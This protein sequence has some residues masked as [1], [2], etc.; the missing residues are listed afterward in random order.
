MRVQVTPGSRSTRRRAVGAIRGSVLAVAILAL[1]A[2][3]QTATETVT[4]TVTKTA[5]TTTTA[6]AAAATRGSATTT[7][8][9]VG[10]RAR[11]R[12]TTRVAWAACDANVDVVAPATSCGFAQNAFYEYWNSGYSATIRVY[13]PALGATLATRCT[14]SATRATCRTGD[15]GRARFALSA[16]EAYSSDQAESYAST[17]DIGPESPSASSWSSDSADDAAT[18]GDDGV[19]PPVGERI[20]NF[21]EGTGYVVRC[22]DGMYSQSGGRPG[23]CSGHG[24]VE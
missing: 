15:G 22:A 20:P 23:A 6:A 19:W 21:D 11:A 3:G 17:H 1:T 14:K 7:H 16:L 12:R 2:C 9:R 10:S 13:S 24:G 4:R 5:A 18:G 8:R